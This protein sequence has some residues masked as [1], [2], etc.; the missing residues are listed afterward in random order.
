M[1]AMHDLSS[2]RKFTFNN[3]M[4]FEYQH[5]L[6]SIIFTEKNTVNQ[7][8]STIIGACTAAIHTYPTCILRVQTFLFAKL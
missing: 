4:T 2:K 8:N 3:H 1:L 5:L 6:L 7:T